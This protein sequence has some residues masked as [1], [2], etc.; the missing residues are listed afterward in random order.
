MVDIIVV[1]VMVD[2][3]VVNVWQPTG[4]NV[5][6]VRVGHKDI[7][8]ALDVVKRDLIDINSVSICYEAALVIG[9]HHDF[10]GAH[11]STQ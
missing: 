1:V 7:A 10:S 3:V 6:S 8:E 5:S 4:V 9:A 11:G 2:I